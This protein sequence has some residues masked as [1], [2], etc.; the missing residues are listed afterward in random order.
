MQ[1]RFNTRLNYQGT[2]LS[3][4]QRQR[5][6]IARA[7]LKKPAVL[8]LD[9]TTNALDEMTKASILRKIKIEYR[10]KIVIFITHDPAVI[11]A[12]DCCV[13]IAR[14]SGTNSR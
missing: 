3:G 11:E 14:E 7:V 10:D 9:E 6:A 4:G 5:I 13:D 1:D 8:L 12:V 2:N